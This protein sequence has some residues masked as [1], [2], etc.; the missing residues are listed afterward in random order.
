MK[1]LHIRHS[2]VGDVQP[3]SCCNRCARRLQ[4]RLHTRY[5]KEMMFWSAGSLSFA[6][7]R[8]YSRTRSIYPAQMSELDKATAS[9]PLPP[10]PLSLSVR[11]RV[12]SS[13]CLSVYTTYRT[14]F[15]GNN[16]KH[17]KRIINARICIQLQVCELT[18]SNTMI[19]RS[20]RKA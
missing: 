15:H 8:H 11:D 20:N 9:L 7:R 14:A 2:I 17:N 13:T 19:A 18:F 10:S 3:I 12:K 16:N 1:Y 6:S 4:R 5:D